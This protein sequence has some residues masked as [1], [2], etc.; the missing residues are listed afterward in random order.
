MRALQR[1]EADFAMGRFGRARPGYLVEDLWGDAYCVV[2]RKDHPTLRGE[3]DEA[4]WRAAGH[5]FAWNAAETAE[6]ASR[7]PDSRIRHVASVPGWVTAMLLVAQTDAIGTVPR[8][9]AERHADT[10]GL[11]VIDLPFPPSRIVLSVMRRTGVQD[12][13]VDWF[14]EQVR[15]AADAA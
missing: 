8:R 1:G 7:E 12:A 11:Q 3:I 14:L 4:T 2:A 10:L 13:G 9:L 15:A 5:V 6:P